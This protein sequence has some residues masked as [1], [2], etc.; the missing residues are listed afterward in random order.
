MTTGGY[1][2]S[3]GTLSGAFGRYKPIAV[4]G[5]GGM[6]TVY[7][8][9]A[10]GHAGFTKLVVVKEL[11]PEVAEDP[12]FMAMFLDEARLAARLSHPNIVQTYEVS[13]EADRH[14]IVM[15]Y[16]DGQPLSRIRSK[17]AEFKEKG[18]AVMLRI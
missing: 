12:E 7:L 10:T 1:P 9:A 18:E 11:K 2:S 5:R 15:E 8:A 16:L 14:A 17:I 3:A 4:L 13:G 6:A